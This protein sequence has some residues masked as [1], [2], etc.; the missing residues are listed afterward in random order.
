MIYLWWY[1]S[2]GGVVAALSFAIH[3][4]KSLKS[5]SP[6]FQAVCVVV[7]IVAWPACLLVELWKFLVNL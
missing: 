7:Y 4:R 1:I 3:G 5:R 2:I 6:G